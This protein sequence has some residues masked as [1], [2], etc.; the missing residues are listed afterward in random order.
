MTAQGSEPIASPANLALAGRMSHER[1]I[2]CALLF[3][4]TVIA[5]VDRAVIANLKN[6]L[7]S[8]IPGL[9]DYTYGI[10]TV[11]FQLAYGIAMLVAGGLTDKLGTRKA[12]AIAICLWSIAAML[13][14][15]A[16]S[17]A[18]FALAMFLLGLGEAANFP[19]CI[20]TVAEW[21][22][23][24][25]R[26]YATGIFNSGAN[27]GN[28][29]APVVVTAF[30]ALFSQWSIFGPARAWRGTFVVAGSLGFVWLA[31]WLILYRRPQEHPRVS[32]AE[33]LLIL[34]DPGEKIESVPW[35]RVAPCKEAWAFAAAKFLTD[36]IWWFYLFWIPGYLQTTFHLSLSQIR[37]P[38]MLAYAISIIGSVGGG[39]ISGALI[40]RG[41]TPNKARKNTMLLC[42]LCIAPI[43]AAPFI[44]HLWVVVALLGLATAGHQGWSATLFTLPSDMFP[45][46]AVA[47]VTGIGGMAGAFGGVLLLFSAGAIVQ[48]THSF[49]T[50]FIIACVAYPLALL[51]IH[52]ISP[53]LAPAQLD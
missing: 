20:K 25:E 40:N 45:K 17:V 43:F 32:K 49:V 37:I 35:S 39:W 18:S 16:F 41:M 3:F 50:L 33:L 6:T 9:D 30:V 14:G 15:L 28:M 27:V 11:A 51:V 5:Y 46:A 36:P 52:A 53:R 22:P 23:K 34:S 31:F 24:R 13:P 2:I 42:V 44:H 4:A 47:S 1:W 8:V 38:V 10:I 48:K 19:A 12:F 21:F 29:V 7:E 26:A